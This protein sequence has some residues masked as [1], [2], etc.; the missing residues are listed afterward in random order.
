MTNYNDKYN[1]PPAEIQAVA[2]LSDPIA[3]ERYAWR[4][5]A[6]VWFWGD[7]SGPNEDAGPF[8]WEEIVGDAH[9]RLT[10]HVVYVSTDD[11]EQLAEALRKI[12]S[13]Q[14][15]IEQLRKE[16]DGARKAYGRASKTIGEQRVFIEALKY[17]IT[18]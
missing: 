11:L 10:E 13:L 12:D 16:R 7:Y 2:D 14:A 18:K 1:P 15:Q 4:E 8:S 9:G 6:D 17:R 5:G 3:D